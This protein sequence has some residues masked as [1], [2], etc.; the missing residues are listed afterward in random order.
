MTAS[1]LPTNSIIYR[2][3]FEAST[4]LL[5]V[6]GGCSWNRC[7]FC[8]MYAGVPFAVE[9]D[10]RI[11]EEI[12]LIARRQPDASRI[13]V[14]NGNAFCLP[15]DKLLRVAG[16]IRRYLPKTDTICIYASIRDIAAKTDE[17]LAALREAG[18]DDVNIGLESGSDEALAFFNKGY[19][20]ATA[21]AQL[22]RMKE[23]GFRYVINVIFGALGTGHAKECAAATAALINKVQPAVVFTETV[24]GEPGS[25]L[26]EDMRTGAFR[27]ATT[28]EYF[29]EMIAFTEALELEDCV[30]Y[31]WH[32]ANI[33]T[34]R[35]RLPEEKETI[36]GYLRA[37]ME[38]L[39]PDTLR[40]RPM[41]FG[42]EGAI[43]SLR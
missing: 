2:P 40:K 36:T 41:R 33:A 7:R 13:F 26:Y 18:Y 22:L 38:E 21:E 24:H 20:A 14:E 35:G 17:E 11:E 16:M 34:V 23:A 27:E 3:P 19:D 25:V 37:R 8:S 42:G 10:A 39:D 30:Y 4:P 31:A 5:Q 28:G 1:N 12:A 6:T 43:L 32:P 15:T 9:N 29:E